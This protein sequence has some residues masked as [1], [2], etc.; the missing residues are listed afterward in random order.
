MGLGDRLARA[1]AEQAELVNDNDEPIMPR[2]YRHAIVL[3]AV[4]EWYLYRKD[5]ARA[6]EALT[7]LLFAR[8]PRSIVVDVTAAPPRDYVDGGVCGTVATLSPFAVAP[9][10]FSTAPSGA[11]PAS[12]SA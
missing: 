2:R 6:Q 5:D 11:S 10:S 3:R 8:C 9:G 7:R 1:G 4:Y 12:I